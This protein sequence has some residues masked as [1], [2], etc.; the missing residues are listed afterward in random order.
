ML[1]GA[2]NAAVGIAAL[3]QRHRWIGWTGWG[4]FVAVA[5]ARTHPRRFA[6]TFAAYLDA[7]QRLWEGQ[8]VYDP[9]TLGDFL[10]FPVTLLI[11][12]PFTFINRVVAAA[13]A[14][15]LA[16]A[17]FTWACTRLTLSLFPPRRHSPDAIAAA[18]VVLLINIPAA[19]FNFKGV[20][21]Q[22]AMT[23]A[24][25]AACA[26]M[27]GSRW[28]AASFWLFVAI[29]MKPLAIVMVLLCGALVREMRLLLAFA[30]AAVLLAPFALLDWSCLAEQYRDMALKLWLIAS[31]LPAQWIYQAD[32]ST[33]VRALGIALPASLALAIRLAAA[34]GTLALAWQ[35][36]RDAG[37]RSF[38]FAVLLLSGCYITLFG[39]RNEFLSFIVLTP[40]LAVLA[41]LILGRDA[42]DHR[43][44]LLI[45]AAVTLGFAWGLKI[46]AALKPAIVA[47]IYLWLAWL[48]AVPA[49]WRTLV[50]GG[51][52]TPS[53]ASERA[54]AGAL[55]AEQR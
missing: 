29:A 51:E 4:I 38:A 17:F 9:T 42:T 6:S 20:Q 41:V 49:R 25:I 2:R 37:A 44:W 12:V 7:A 36:R 45:L 48:M 46:D 14:L 27:I 28:R 15:A 52:T 35:I 11:Y 18:A 26:A 53:S 32:F 1:R 54:M 10:Y 21:A 13:L 23:A 55:T 24:M 40:S 50:E 30:V 22:V 34:L 19:W 47:V 8:Q 33:L 3:F 31:A 16:A 5:L 43:G 39:P